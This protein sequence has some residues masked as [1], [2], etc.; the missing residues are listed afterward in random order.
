MADKHPY[1]P[2]G[3][4]GIAA[5]INQLRKAFPKT[6]DAETL[7]KLSIAPKN[8]SY[9]INVLRFIGVI[10]A[11]GNKTEKA[12]A[13]FSKPD[14]EF[15]EAFA[16]MVRAA[17]SGLFDLHTD[18]AWTLP[19][20]KLMSYFRSAD[21][22]SELVGR[23]QAATFQLLASFAGHGEPPAAPGSKSSVKAKSPKPAKVKG[24]SPAAEPPNGPANNGLR[25]FGLTVRIEV[26]LPA[27]G[28]QETYD[29]IFRSIRENLFPNAK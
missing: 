29:K 24:D 9:V 12:A 7:R 20:E 25:D 10:D 15:K 28:D 2:G 27:G 1:S 14:D 19:P 23:H 6:V 13:A 17:Y 26:N 18:S 11:S 22:T 3:M 5:A 8:E 16:E 21:Q 4:G